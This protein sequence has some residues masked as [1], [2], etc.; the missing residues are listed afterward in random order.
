[1]TGCFVTHIR[2]IV[3]L[4]IAGILGFIPFLRAHALEYPIHG[5]L[6]FEYANATS[7]D[8]SLEQKEAL[9]ARFVG[10]L[11][12]LSESRL[13]IKVVTQGGEGSVSTLRRL[14]LRRAL[15]L[16]QFFAGFG[17]AKDRI[18]LLPLGKTGEKQLKNAVECAIRLH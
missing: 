9:R 5:S 3:L 11:K 2:I 7:E 17:I 13:E 12:D 4:G 15:A 6:S 8:L 14:S 18:D 16:E 1:M 10:M